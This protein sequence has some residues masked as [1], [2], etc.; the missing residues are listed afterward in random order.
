M[1]KPKKR[2]AKGSP[3]PYT[4]AHHPRAR[5]TLEL[6]ADREEMATA[7][8]RGAL[9]GSPLL[10]SPISSTSGYNKHG[11]HDGPSKTNMK[12]WQRL[13]QA[14]GFLHRIT[15]KVLSV[16]KQEQQGEAVGG[17]LRPFSHKQQTCA[18][19]HKH[20]GPSGPVP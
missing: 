10:Q 18:C 8:G 9:P 7:A 1:P 2:K 15:A 12:S 11:P 13:K 5:M 16:R 3:T 20:G 19:T 4:S 6:T 14:K 17:R